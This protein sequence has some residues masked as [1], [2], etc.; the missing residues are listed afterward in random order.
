MTGA[1]FGSR[2]SRPIESGGFRLET[3]GFQEG[4]MTALPLTTERKSRRLMCRRKQT[5]QGIVEYAAILGFVS[6]LVGFGFAF[7]N[8]SLGTALTTAFASIS[9]QLNSLN[10][11]GAGS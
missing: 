3:A 5:G 11:N 6:V 2:L 1:I 10:A 4:S 9:A 7:I 8:G